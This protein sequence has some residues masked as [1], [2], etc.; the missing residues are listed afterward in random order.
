[1]I[2]DGIVAGREEASLVQREVSAQR[3]DGGIVREISNY[4]IAKGF[5][6]GK[7]SPSQKSEIFASPLYTRGPLKTG[8]S[9][10]TSTVG[11]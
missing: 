8:A 9:P 11:A 6:Y 1:M 2:D 10:V 3:A 5:I 4:A 7:Q